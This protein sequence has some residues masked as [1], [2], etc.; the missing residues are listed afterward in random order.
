MRIRLDFIR[1]TEKARLY[2]DRDG[3][4]F[5]V[6]KSVTTHTTKYPQSDP[7]RFTVHE[8]EIADWWWDKHEGVNKELYDPDEE[9]EFYS[10]EDNRR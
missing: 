5:W 6:P 9:D 7:L 10:D 4:E 8:V 2:S 1:E 3:T